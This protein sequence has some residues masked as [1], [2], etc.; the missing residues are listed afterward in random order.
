[1]ID[2]VMFAVARLY[3]RVHEFIHVHLGYNIRGLG[4]LLRMIKKDRI[5]SVQGKSLYFDSSIADCYDRLVNGRYN[6]PETHTF[7]HRL[8]NHHPETS[9]QF[10]DIGANV[11]EFV[12][13]LGS[14]HRVSKILAFEPQPSCAAALVKTSNLNNFANVR[15]VEKAV[16]D[17]I[18]HVKMERRIKGRSGTGILLPGEEGVEVLST[19]IDSEALDVSTPSIVLIDAEGAELHII[20]GARKFIRE[21]KPLIIFEYNHI[22]K[23]HF[24]L[25]DIQKELG[26]PYVMY[27]LRADGFLDKAFDKTWNIV[28]ISREGA[29]SG[30]FLHSMS[31][32]ES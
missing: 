7:I 30:A 20:I 26:D 23:I 16:T 6:E 21:N 27:R 15:I 11:G 8:L 5:L 1:M 13:D 24:T 31:R 2:T 10:I 17:A 3:S 28:A 29:I 9:F 25:D 19:T 32:M 12:I 22:S 4:Y 18:G 14:S